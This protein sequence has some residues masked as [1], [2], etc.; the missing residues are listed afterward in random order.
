MQSWMVPELSLSSEAHQELDR[1]RAARLP[2]I[3]LQ[4]VADRL[5]C[6]WY[7]HEKMLD[8]ALRRVAALEVELALSK[9]PS[10]QGKNPPRA[11]HHQWAQEVMGQITSGSCSTSDEAA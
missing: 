3:E 11:E 10:T 9:V 6:D 4:I 8:C 5:I 2:L 7:R 1:R